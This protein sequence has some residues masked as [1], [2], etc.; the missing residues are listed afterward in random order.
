MLCGD[1]CGVI[2][3]FDLKKGDIVDVRYFERGLVSD[4]LQEMRKYDP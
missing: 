2:F 4:L 3:E 1:F